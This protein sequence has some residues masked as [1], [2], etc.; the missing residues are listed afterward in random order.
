MST[1]PSPSAEKKSNYSSPAVDKAVDVIEFLASRREAVSI[2]AISEGI[3]R[4]VGEIY[5]VVRALERRRLVYKNPNTDRFQLS[6][7]L[8]ELAHKFPPVER[9]I[10][11]AQPELDALS[12]KTLQSCHLGVVEG[13]KIIVAASKESPL[14]MHYSVRVG[15]G[16]Q[17]FETSSGTVLAAFSSAPRQEFLLTGTK[18]AERKGL[19]KRFEQIVEQGYELRESDTVDG[20]TNITVPVSSQEG[21]ILAALTVPYLKQPTA[22]LGP[23]AVLELQIAA[24][25]RISRGLG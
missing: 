8:F 4:S 5:R 22:P 23:E 1:S 2:T 15:S 11:V 3:G 16:F 25:Q 10:R 13:R 6:L 19:E 7:R 14:P 18:T 21:K 20:L 17:L 12:E 24:G 9:L